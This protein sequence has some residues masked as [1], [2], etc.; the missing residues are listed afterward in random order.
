MVMITTIIM[1]IRQTR[2][3]AATRDRVCADCGGKGGTNVKSCTGCKG[4]GVKIQTIQVGREKVEK[5]KT[6]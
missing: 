4:R 3:L 1:M 2:K 6:K 5:G